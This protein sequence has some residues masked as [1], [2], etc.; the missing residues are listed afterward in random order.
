M[1]GRGQRAQDL[2]KLAGGELARSTRAV[3]ELCQAAHRGLGGHGREPTFR[4][5]PPGTRT[6]G[7]RPAQHTGQR[8]EAFMITEA[9]R[10]VPRLP[11]P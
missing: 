9:Q 1:G 2:R 5:R 6:G 7:T 11:G 10:P 3:A 4:R 8:A